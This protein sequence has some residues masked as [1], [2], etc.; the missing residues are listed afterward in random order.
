MKLIGLRDAI[1]ECII[2]IITEK[3]DEGLVQTASKTGSS[4]VKKTGSLVKKPASF[5]MKNKR[6][7]A[8]GAAGGVGGHKAKS[9]FDSKY[10]VQIKKKKGIKKK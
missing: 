8:I 7:T 1:K 6:A 2:E 4:L 5:A 10:N 9:N 3:I